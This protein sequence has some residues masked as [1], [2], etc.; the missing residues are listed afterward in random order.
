[1]FNFEQK[2]KI[3]YILHVIRIKLSERDDNLIPEHG[4]MS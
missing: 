3:K 1:M 4:L 2:E